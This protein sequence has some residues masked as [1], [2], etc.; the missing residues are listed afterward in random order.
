[1]PAECRRPHRAAAHHAARE[2]HAG[3]CVH[4]SNYAGTVVRF[5]PRCEH[6]ANVD[7][8]AAILRRGRREGRQLRVV[9]R[10]HSYNDVF[11][12]DGCMISLERFDRISALDRAR[13][14][15]T[16]DAGVT[17]SSGSTCHLAQPPG[18]VAY[19]ADRPPP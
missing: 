19:L 10:L 16:C 7:E 8:L 11:F 9:G 13:G 1:M 15:V 14:T 12:S 3:P 2:A 6:P 17:I 5:G 4:I 18:P